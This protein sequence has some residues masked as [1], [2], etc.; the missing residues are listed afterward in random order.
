MPALLPPVQVAQIGYVVADIEAAGRR[1]HELY[2]LGPIFRTQPHPL[3][4]VVHRGAAT[5][6]EIETAFAQSGDVQIEL[7]QQ[8]S[9]G[10]SAYRDQFG[11]GEHG[12]HHVATWSTDYEAEKQAYL[13]AGYEI[14]MEMGGYGDYRI[15]Y[16][17]TRPLLGHMLELYP[18]EPGL[19]RMYAYVRE[20]TAAWD[21]AELFQ[22]LSLDQVT[23]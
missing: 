1:L 11:E 10:P 8:T 23:R 16:V 21:G 19:R 5:P 12:L 14:A 22:P 3:R 17:D 2:R 13:D 15:C 18:D 4:D 6:V 20:R 7:I 9:A